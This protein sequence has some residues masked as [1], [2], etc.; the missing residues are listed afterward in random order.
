MAAALREVDAKLGTLHPLL[1]GESEIRSGKEMLSRNPAKPAE[2]VGRLETAGAAE[3]DLAISAAAAALESW[4]DTEP[5]GRA[6]ILERMPSSSA[7][8]ASSSRRSRCSRPG[9]RG[10]RQ[11]LTSAKPSISVATMQAKCAAL[12]APH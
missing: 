1:I 5:E 7:S 11:M 4:R 2:I 10:A 6:M 9:R 3:V 12:P 8:D